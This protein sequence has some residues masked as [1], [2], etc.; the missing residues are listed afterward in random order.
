MTIHGK[1]KLW[2]SAASCYDWT[3]LHPTP[4]TLH[5]T[6]YTLHPTP[7]TLHPTPYT[8]HPV[9][10]SLHPTPYIVHPV[11]YTLHPIPCYLYPIPETRSTPDI[12]KIRCKLRVLGDGGVRPISVGISS[13]GYRV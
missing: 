6:P 5:P 3:S 13:S 10:Y 12:P 7:Y 8:L 2:S 11:P 4:Y 9:P 1:I